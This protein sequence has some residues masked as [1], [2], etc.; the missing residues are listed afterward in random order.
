[1]GCTV[2]PVLFVLS[3]QL[4]L[5]VTENESNFVE[6]G[7]GCQMPAVKAFMD[8]TTVLSSKESTTQKLIS[9]MDELMIWCRM[10]FKP[11][12]SR[13]LSLRYFE[14]GG[15]RI[16]TVSDLP[17]KSQVCWYDESMKDTNQV[18]ETSKTLQEGLFKID[19]C[20]L[21]GKYKV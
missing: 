4:L 14:I 16:P 21:Q 13:S 12:K 3:M 18:K 15:Q 10:K 5:K 17:V 19:C 9:F 11:Q 1:M 2:S 6:L 7:R 20:P 8:D